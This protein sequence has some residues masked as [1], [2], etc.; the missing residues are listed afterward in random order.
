M[1]I[2]KIALVLLF[3]LGLSVQQEQ[4]LGMKRLNDLRNKSL[5]SPN[6]IIPFTIK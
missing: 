5:T 1:N 6:R 2:I 3:L 4:D